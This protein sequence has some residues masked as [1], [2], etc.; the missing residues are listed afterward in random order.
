MKTTAFLIVIY[1]TTLGL[2]AQFS[3]EQIAS[4]PHKAEVKQIDPFQFAYYEYRGSYTN[5]YTAFPNL[6]EYINLCIDSRQV[7]KDRSA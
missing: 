4:Y 5:A 6:V 2:S 3:N 7:E 1:F